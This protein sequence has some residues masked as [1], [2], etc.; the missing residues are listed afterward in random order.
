[1]SGD[2]NVVA[3]F[4]TH[5]R[6]EVFITPQA[7]K[8]ALFLKMKYCFT[9][10]ANPLKRISASRRCA[11]IATLETVMLMSI[12]ALCAYGVYQIVSQFI[13]WTSGAVVTMLNS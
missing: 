6:R 11:G 12:A 1:M 13:S 5:S 10:K 7:G 2:L 9:R 3:H 8:S 4:R